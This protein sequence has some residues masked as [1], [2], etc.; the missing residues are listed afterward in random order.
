MDNS[1][2]VIW[3]FVH[4]TLR[5]KTFEP[6]NFGHHFMFLVVRTCGNDSSDA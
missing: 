3:E 2:I 6:A 1:M 5:R 4:E